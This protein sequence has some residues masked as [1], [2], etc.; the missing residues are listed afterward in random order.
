MIE[1]I[2]P[3]ALLD[4]LRERANRVAD[5]LRWATKQADRLNREFEAHEGIPLVCFGRFCD[6]VQHKLGRS[7]L[8]NPQATSA[9]RWD[10]PDGERSAVGRQGHDVRLVDRRETWPALAARWKD[11][12]NHYCS[13]WFT[14]NCDMCL[15]RQRAGMCPTQP[16]SDLRFN[17]PGHESVGR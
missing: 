8:P 2:N 3:M 5:D 4:M 13:G 15:D 7:G 9:K 16:W 12:K 17:T 14:D 10:I 1:T 11:C 6:V